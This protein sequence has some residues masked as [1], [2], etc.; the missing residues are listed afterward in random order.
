MLNSVPYQVS[1]PV[2]MT[3]KPQVYFNYYNHNLQTTNPSYYYNYHQ[4]KPILQH[5]YLQFTYP[6]P[7]NIYRNDIEYMNY[8]IPQIIG[9]RLNEIYPGISN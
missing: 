7:P 5:H 3:T 9:R 1:N 6:Y 8:S 2:S 4:K